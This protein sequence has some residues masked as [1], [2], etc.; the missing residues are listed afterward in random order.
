[1]LRSI[2]ETMRYSV[3]WIVGLYYYGVVYANM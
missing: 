2:I 3:F 1:Y